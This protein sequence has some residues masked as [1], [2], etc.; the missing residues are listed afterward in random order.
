[1]RRCVRTLGF[2]AGAAEDDDDEGDEGNEKRAGE[3]RG[4]DDGDDDADDDEGKG[5]DATKRRNEGRWADSLHQLE[6]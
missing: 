6:W 3:T 1:M 4:R 5:V 2:G